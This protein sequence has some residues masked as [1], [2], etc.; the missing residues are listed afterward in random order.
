MTDPKYVRPGLDFARGKAI[1]E[2]GELLAALG[3]SL[4]WGWLSRNPESGASSEINADWVRR[5]MADMRGAL[6]NLEREMNSA[7]VCGGAL[8]QGIYTCLER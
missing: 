7:S 5:E 6:D 2:A 3:K 4:R 1:E 8:Y